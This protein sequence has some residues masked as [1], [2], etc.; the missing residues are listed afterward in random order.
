MVFFDYT[1]PHSARLSE[2]LDTAGGRQP[3]WSPFPLADPNRAGDGP[4]V[5]QWPDALARPALLALALHKTVIAGRGDIDGFRRAV[6]AAFAAQPVTP[7]ELYI[8]AAAASA[9]TDEAGVHRK[10]TAVAASSEMG[11]AAG[12]VATPSVLTDGG[13]LG[14]PKLTGL[15]T[16]RP[17]RQRL[18]EVTLTVINDCPELSKIM[19]PTTS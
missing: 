2:L 13:Q 19:R 4:P 12:V 11:R 18:L 6:F 15:P 16:G 10:L 5:W 14:H 7:D 3:R 1:C 8:L 9:R 17:A